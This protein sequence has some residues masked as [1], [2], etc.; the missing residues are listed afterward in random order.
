MLWAITVATLHTEISNLKVWIRGLVRTWLASLFSAA[1]SLQILNLMDVMFLS[2]H[3]SFRC[4]CVLIS[5][6][7]FKIFLMFCFF[8]FPE[9]V[10]T[11]PYSHHISWR[12]WKRP[13][14][15]RITR[16]F[17]RARCWP[18]KQSCLRTG[19]RWAWL[20]IQSGF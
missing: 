17:T 2:I 11:E 4:V 13:L 7:C 6:P 9:P 20:L 8:S 3:F 12:S 15:K 16:M 18:W 14:M 5:L 19:Y 10:S 1:P